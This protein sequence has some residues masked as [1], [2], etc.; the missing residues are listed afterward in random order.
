MLAYILN[1]WKTTAAGVALVLKGILSALG[2]GDPATAV[3][4]IVMG[5]GLIFAKDG[6]VTGVKQ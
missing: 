1:N 6:D 2:Y 3:T 4:D 5:I